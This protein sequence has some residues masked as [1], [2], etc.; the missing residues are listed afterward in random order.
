MPC[1]D[2]IYTVH[3]SVGYSK[4]VIFTGRSFSLFLSIA[5]HSLH[6]SGSI[7]DMKYQDS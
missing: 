3:S 6:L 2:T 1:M 7:P 5:E 4:K